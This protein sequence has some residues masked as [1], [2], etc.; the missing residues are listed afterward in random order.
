MRTGWGCGAVLAITG[1]V[2]AGVVVELVPEP[3]PFLGRYYLPDQ[4][5]RT[6]VFIRQDPAAEDHF[7][8]YLQFDFSNSHPELG[9]SLPVPQARAGIHFWDFESTR[10]DTG[11]LYEIDDDLL[12]SPSSLISVSWDRPFPL[13]DL[14]LILPGNGDPIRIGIIDARMPYFL[15][16]VQLDFLN[17]DASDPS[18]GAE[19]RFGFGTD[20]PPTTWRAE[21]G[22]IR[23]GRFTYQIIPEP[24][25]LTLLVGGVMLIRRRR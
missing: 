7:I 14:G 13:P 19:L 25:T 16:E 18:L 21:F 1:V 8:R 24:T 9:L 22:D 15:P 20:E 23:G 11:V 6:E 12:G 4:V 3:P 10:L 2:R 17:A 5:V